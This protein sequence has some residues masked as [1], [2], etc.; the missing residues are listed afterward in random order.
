[1]TDERAGQLNE[2][3]IMKGCGDVI[4]NAFCLWN[5]S[6]MSLWD[7]YPGPEEFAGIQVLKHLV[8]RGLINELGIEILKRDGVIK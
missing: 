8:S 1:M 3:N 2:P 5:R 6:G 4:Y 7:K